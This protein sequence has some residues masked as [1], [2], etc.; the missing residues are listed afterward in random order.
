M[1]FKKA[2]V[3]GTLMQALSAHAQPP[4]EVQWMVEIPTTASILSGLIDPS[5]GQVHVLFSDEGAG[6]FCYYEESGRILGSNGLPIVF[7]DFCLD[8]GVSLDHWAASAMRSTLGRTYALNVS[9]VGNPN[10]SH[11]FLTGLGEI[12]SYYQ[13]PPNFGYAYAHSVFA[14]GDT[15]YV[16]GT[17]VDCWPPSPGTVY[18]IGGTYWRA[19]MPQF[20]NSL[21]AT[22]DS[23]LAIRFPSVFML[24]KSTGTMGSNFDLFTGA[25]TNTGTSS[26]DGD[27]LYWAIVVNGN[28]RVGKYIIGQGPAWEQTL[29]FIHPPAGLELDAYGRLWTAVD[30]KL[31]WLN[32]SDGTYAYVTQ[33]TVINTLD[34]HLGFLLI[35]GKLGTDV[36][37][38]SKALP[39]P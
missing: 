22:A 2:I 15:L 30:N 29:P 1:L 36:A 19:C 10:H 12:Q 7:T 8:A 31:I 6:G 26:L 3:L 38:I 21:E 13:G 5:T 34:I 37:F 17:D 35:T 23:I 25:V 24:D 4:L 33:G 27:S 28:T 20:I 9:T 39:T 11:I 14:N 32:A 16:G 18:K